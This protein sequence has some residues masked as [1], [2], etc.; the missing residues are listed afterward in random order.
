L[1][2]PRLV[3]AELT[4]KNHLTAELAQ[5]LSQV[6]ELTSPPEAGEEVVPLSA[7]TGET[8]LESVKELVA[9]TKEQASKIGE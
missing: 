2:S 3:Q 5:K 8:L 4:D 6:R 9:T 7:Q 1:P